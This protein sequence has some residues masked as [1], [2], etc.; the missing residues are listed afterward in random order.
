MLKY[1]LFICLLCVLNLNLLFAA[2]VEIKDTSVKAGQLIKIPVYGNIDQIG[3]SYSLIL[4][5]NSLQLDVKRIIGGSDLG[6]TEDHP[7]FSSNIHSLDSIDLSINSNNIKSPYN[8]VLFYIEAEAL[9]S[10]DSIATI[11]PVLFKV[12]NNEPSNIDYKQGNVKI[13]GPIVNQIYPEGFGIAYPNPSREKITV[14]FNIKTD[15]KVKFKIYNSAGAEV[16]AYPETCCMINFE[17]FDNKNNPINDK[18]YTFKKG[19]YKLVLKPNSW[20]FS[21]GVYLLMMEANSSVYKINI[22]YVK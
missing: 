21:T 7:S 5:Y 3:S 2:S 13:I 15:S 22:V 16:E 18:N 14:E 17:V 8:G 10:S 11:T 1:L 20:N 6:F 19:A 9:V 12:D 4:N